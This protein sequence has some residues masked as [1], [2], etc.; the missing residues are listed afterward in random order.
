MKAKHKK[1]TKTHIET[2]ENHIKIYI[3]GPGARN[4]VKWA[5]LMWVQKNQG[6]QIHYETN[7]IFNQAIYL[8]SENGD[9]LVAEDYL[10][11]ALIS[12]SVDLRTSKELLPS[13]S[14]SG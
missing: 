2:I 13:D 9:E 6:M 12:E 5:P 11:L 1:Y 4:S 8:A 10:L 14:I 7:K 3:P